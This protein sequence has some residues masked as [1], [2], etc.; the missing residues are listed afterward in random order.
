MPETKLA[1]ATLERTWLS[2][3]AKY[4]DTDRK[5]AALAGIFASMEWHKRTKKQ[6]VPMMQAHVINAAI[7]QLRLPNV[8]HISYSSVY[9]GRY[10][11]ISIEA[12]YTEGRSRLYILDRGDETVT[13]ASDLWRK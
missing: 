11:V 13:L 7:R 9:M 12:H 2:N 10:S 5:K 4:H 3:S 6:K 1:E 8:S